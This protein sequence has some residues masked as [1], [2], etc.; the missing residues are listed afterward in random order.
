MGLGRSFG[1][2]S[3][4]GMVANAHGLVS[5]S[6]SSTGELPQTAAVIEGVLDALLQRTLSSMAG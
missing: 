5:A 6:L 2:V 1:G 3:P 4:S